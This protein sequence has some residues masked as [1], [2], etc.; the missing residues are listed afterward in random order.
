[1]KPNQFDERYWNYYLNLESD[2]IATQ[3]YIAIDPDNF[4]AFS[5]EYAKQYQTICSEVDVVCKQY[6]NHLCSSKNPS[7]ILGYADV[8]LY[9]KADVKSRIVRVKNQSNIQLVP[10]KDWNS[11]P[12]D[13][14]NGNNPN[15]ISPTWWT[16]Y[17]KVKHKRTSSDSNGQEFFKKANLVNTINALAGLFILEMYF[18]KDLVIAEGIHDITIPNRSSELF[19]I[20]DWERHLSMVANGFVVCDI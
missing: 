2:F 4:D 3:R 18:Y 1:M 13:P 20:D 7:N 14:L 16:I 17:N 6:C 9:E 19:T 10:W 12:N 5:L 11:D 15:N 8:I